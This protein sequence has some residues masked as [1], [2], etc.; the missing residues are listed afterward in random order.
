MGPFHIHINVHVLYHKYEV[1]FD[2]FLGQEKN[3]SNY[4]LHQDRSS[5]MKFHNHCR[6]YAI[7]FIK[8]NSNRYII[9]QVL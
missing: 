8:E 5:K 2:F 6:N 1:Y 3:K 4:T 9:S 7:I